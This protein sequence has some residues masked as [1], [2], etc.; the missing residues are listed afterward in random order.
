MFYSL[1]SDVMLPPSVSSP[2]V[3]HKNEQNHQQRV[4]Q[5]NNYIH[6]N[7]ESILL[8][9]TFKYIVTKIINKV[10]MTWK[11]TTL[12]FHTLVPFLYTYLQV[13][14]AF[15]SLLPHSGKAAL[16]GCVCPVAFSSQTPPESRT[17]LDRKHMLMHRQELQ[18]R[19]TY[20]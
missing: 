15:F 6:Y 3:S 7:T 18:E 4:A 17:L 10:G 14:F 20:F 2:T 1:W 11:V 8:I 13:V 19:K 9:K 12:S 16:S 5:V